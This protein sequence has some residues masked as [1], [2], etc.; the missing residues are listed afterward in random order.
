[1]RVG[2]EYF[3]FDPEMPAQVARPSSPNLNSSQMLN[4]PFNRLLRHP[5]EE[6]CIF[7]TRKTPMRDNKDL[8]IHVCCNKNFHNLNF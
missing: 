7:Q 1:M 6:W 5:Q 2:K 8:K 3:I 4:G